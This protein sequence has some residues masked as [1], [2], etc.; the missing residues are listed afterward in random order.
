M[1]LAKV[2]R[3]SI[4]RRR[5]AAGMAATAVAVAMAVGSG[6]PAMAYGSVTVGAPFGCTGHAYGISSVSGTTA[7]SSTSESGNFCVATNLVNAALRTAGS[8]TQWNGKS[9]VGYI[10][11]SGRAADYVGGWHNWGS[12]KVAS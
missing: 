7:Y 5:V 3:P 11:V 8:T 10:Q 4:T 1:Q 6:V 2:R 12:N 9:G